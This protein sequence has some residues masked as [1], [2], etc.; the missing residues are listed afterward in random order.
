M[1]GPCGNGFKMRLPV[2]NIKTAILHPEEEVRLRAVRYFADSNSD[3]VTIMPLVMEAVE[4]YGRKSAFSILRDAENLIQ[5]ASTLDWLIHELCRDYDL[6]LVNDDNVRF[7]LALAILAA[8]VDLLTARKPEIDALSCFPIELRGPLD[9]RIQ[10]ATWSWEQAW[11][12]L[13][14]FG[15][16]TMRKRE[17]SLIESR[18]ALRLLETL[19]RHQDRTVDVLDLFRR[20]GCCEDRLLNWLEPEIVK[21]AG[22]MGSKLAIPLLVHYL[23]HKDGSLS[24]AAATALMCLRSDDVVKAVADVWWDADE[25]FRGTA[26]EVLEKIHTDLCIEKCLDFLDAEDGL[27][28]ALAVGHAALSHFAVEAVSPVRDL[29]VDIRGELRP[30][31]YDL[32]YYLT[33]TTTIMGVKFPEYDAWYQLALKNNWGWGTYKRGRMADN[34]RPRPERPK[35][36]QTDA[37]RLPLEKVKQALLH[38]EPAVREAALTYFARSHSADPTIMPSAIQSIEQF[39]YEAFSVL[40][41]AKHVPNLANLVQTD[42]SVAWLIRKIESLGT[43]LDDRDDNFRASLISTLRRVDADLLERYESEI[44][45]MKALDD[46]SRE[47]VADRISVGS[48]TPDALWRELINFCDVGHD[49]EELS[50]RD[51]EYIGSVAQALGRF[52]E[53]IVDR[54][55]TVLAEADGS[56]DWLEGLVIELAGNL[57]LESAVPFLVDR[58]NECGEWPCE[59]AHEALAKIGTDAVV[60]E[61]ADRYLDS[62]PPF[63]L[64]AATTLEDVHTDLVVPTCLDL[65][66]QEQDA[67]LQFHLLESMLL[68]F[69]PEAV[70]PARQ[71]VLRSE[72]SPDVLEVRSTLLIACKVME[73]TFPEFEDWLAD[74]QHD[75]ETRKRW[76]ADHPLSTHDNA[77]FND[78]ESDDALADEAFEKDD[79]G[80]SDDVV[81]PLTIVRR[82]EHVGRNDPCPCGSGK[83]YKKCCYG[84]VPDETDEGRAAVISSVRPIKSPP[85]YPIGTVA[86]YGP[87]DKITTKIVAGVVKR[88]GDEAIVERW[89]GTNI[90][91]NPKVQ[92]QIKQFFD[93]YGVKSVVA[94]DMNFGCPHEEG[95][96]FPAGED[97]PFCAYWAGKQGRNRR[98]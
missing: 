27:D 95:A 8:P 17:V 65:F 97:C 85:K 22:R 57:R 23:G 33:A 90:K 37:T 11:Q 43:L 84:K 32:R 52:P 73:R 44:Q 51:Y 50:D 69:S 63:R 10:M 30:D 88:E 75:V 49:P 34:F 21:L 82:S 13:E 15:R 74:S 87:D 4:K 25:D 54:V 38:P 42:A 70:E 18:H 59:Q 16:R 40:S 80:E 89:M 29:L 41:V 35:R 83:K 77:D 72:K 20:A 2:E 62:E 76:Y 94:T 9:E 26:A 12:A 53:Q 86:L 68:N 93:R 79:W 36:S 67:E 6:R 7:A 55:L 47:I 48:L 56:N 66:E 1:T 58:F 64:A 81:P 39:G 92:R 19:S 24:D 71:Y 98:Y 78:E 96:D 45:A 28:T 60:R 61:I 5:T 46:E 3:D 14:E 91:N 31:E